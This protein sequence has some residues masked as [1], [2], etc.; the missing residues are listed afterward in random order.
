MHTLSSF[1]VIIRS[2]LIAASFSNKK[3]QKRIDS[4]LICFYINETSYI[5]Y[6]K[7]NSEENKVFPTLKYE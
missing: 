2:N 7:V 5:K 4:L 3:L 6:I 1:T